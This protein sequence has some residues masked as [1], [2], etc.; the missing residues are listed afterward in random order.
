[1]K[2]IAMAAGAILLLVGAALAQ[3]NTVPQ[4]GVDTAIV[5][6]NTYSAVSIGLV[7]AA[8]ATDIFCISGSS[9]KAISIKRI[10]ISGTAGTL[11]S[12]PFTL[13]RRA[14]LDTGGTAATT[15]ALPVA[16]AHLSTQPAATATLVAYTANPTIV[17]ASPIYFAS[18]YTTLPVTT[19]GT[20]INPIIWRFG[21][22]SSWF[23]R[24][25]DIPSG[26]T[27]QQYC[28]NLN[29][30]TVTSGVLHIDTTWVEN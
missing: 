25:L 24:A 28:I 21:E 27:A 19:A 22:E 20:S 7:P 2:R 30:V 4:I 1:M 16:S 8:S 10:A 18:Q 26:S 9:S 29:A 5:K 23:S 13:L 12:A 11:V 17:D 3:V 15:T 14:S 6:Q